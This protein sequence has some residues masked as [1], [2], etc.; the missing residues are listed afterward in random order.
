MTQA[1]TRGF[2]SWAQLEVGGHQTLAGF[3]PEFAFV[4]KDVCLEKNV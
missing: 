4:L 2:H 3:K 1:L